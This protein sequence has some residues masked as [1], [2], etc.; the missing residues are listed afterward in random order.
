MYTV[1]SN[2][3]IEFEEGH[4]GAPTVNSYRYDEQK[5]L[6]ELQV[7]RFEK[8]REE[9]LD[10]V[11]ANRHGKNVGLAYDLA[12]G[13]VANEDVFATIALYEAGQ[14][15]KAET[16]TRFKV[17]EL[18]VQYLFHTVKALGMLMPTA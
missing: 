5:G 15:S 11:V 2:C 16:I 4:V 9:R 18:Y 3:Q 12:I 13:P 1:L 8:A 10:F 6:A 14:L 7:L 17:K